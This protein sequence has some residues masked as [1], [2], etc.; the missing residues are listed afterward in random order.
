MGEKAQMFIS[1]DKV[2]GLQN[3]GIRAS[4]GHLAL[5]CGRKIITDRKCAKNST[6]I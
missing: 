3:G 1:Y 6:E 5:A 4:V 2:C